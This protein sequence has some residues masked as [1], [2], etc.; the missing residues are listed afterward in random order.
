MDL[1]EW[2]FPF[3]GIIVIIIYVMFSKNNKRLK[4]LV[5]VVIIGVYCIYYFMGYLFNS[6][7]LNAITFHRHGFTINII[8][9]EVL[10]ATTVLVLYFIQKYMNKRKNK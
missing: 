4:I 6:N 9:F 10:F 1:F 2:V 7:I 3:T 8:G 5:L